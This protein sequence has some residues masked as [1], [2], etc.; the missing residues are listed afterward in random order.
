M[1]DFFYDKTEEDK[2][3]STFKDIRDIYLNKKEITPKLFLFFGEKLSSLASLEEKAEGVTRKIINKVFHNKECRKL[4]LKEKEIFL[5]IIRKSEDAIHDF[6]DKIRVALED[7]ENEEHDDELLKFA[8]DLGI[9]LIEE[10][11]GKEEK[12]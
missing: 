7:E 8:E 2:L 12:E 10:G 3:K 11:E 4:I 5:D 9:L 6:E 1:T